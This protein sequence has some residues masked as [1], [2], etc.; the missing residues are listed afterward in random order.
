MLG[1]SDVVDRVTKA[2]GRA[3]VVA[4]V[5]PRQCGKSTLAR[6]L[7]RGTEDAYFDLEH[8]ADL[9]RLGSPMTSLEPLRGLVVIDEVQHRPDLFPMLRVLADRPRTPAR[10]LV[11]GSASPT[12]L[13]QS[14]ES[15]A[16][17]IETIVMGGFTPDE[18]AS[19]PSASKPR[20]SRSAGTPTTR[21]MR[22]WERG[23]FPRS[24]LARTNADSFTWRTEFVR[25]SLE[26]NLPQLGI[27]IPAITLLRFWTMLAHWHGQ[28][29]NAAEFARSLGTAEAT[30][31]RYLDLLSDLYLVR[32][33]QPWFANIA[34]RQVKSPKVYVR[35]SGLLHALL[36]IDGRSALLTNPRVGASWE[37]WVIE[38]ILA[39]IRPDTASFWATHQGAELDLFL[40]H[41]G[42]RVGVEVKR[43]DAPTITPSIRHALI[44][45]ELDRVLVIHPGSKPYRLSEQIDVVPA[46]VLD[47]R[48]ALARALGLGPA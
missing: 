29:W 37:G 13:R 2:L 16:G 48:N 17:R 15:L 33:L 35:D 46:S 41:R 36:G 26:R 11:L 27:S 32:Q 30:A 25:T 8:P 5:G 40:I 38:S 24:Y 14:S 19:D 12:L 23:G 6:A 42:R 22:H 43:S 39:T 34:K 18:V 31:R 7:F 10:F 47:D 44:D 9:A 4:L 45:L 20:S 28:V 21:A 1:R 3:P